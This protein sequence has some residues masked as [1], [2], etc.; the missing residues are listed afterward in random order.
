MVTMGCS[1]VYY[2][3][4]KARAPA[5]GSGPSS[6]SSPS[7]SSS[8]PSSS[9]FDNRGAAARRVITGHV[10]SQQHQTSQN[11]RAC[12]RSHDLKYAN[13]DMTTSLVKHQRD[14][15]TGFTWRC[16]MHRTTFFLFSFFS[17]TYARVLHKPRL[18]LS[19]S[20][21]KILEKSIILS[22]APLQQ[23]HQQ[24]RY[25]CWSISRVVHWQSMGLV[26]RLHARSSLRTFIIYYCLA[27]VDFNEW[28]SLAFVIL[29]HIILCNSPHAL[30]LSLSLYDAVLIFYFTLPHA[31]RCAA[32]CRILYSGLIVLNNLI[33]PELWLIM[34]TRLVR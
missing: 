32:L 13:G 20:G 16:C 9:F 28:I 34:I 8:S 17:N 22:P 30:S 25:V 18:R 21:R 29:F 23:Q 15:F 1:G 33:V 6:S 4:T 19:S 26:P 27:R 11:T 5:A 24:Q 12:T 10:L 3:M 14:S 31:L 7:A 2:I